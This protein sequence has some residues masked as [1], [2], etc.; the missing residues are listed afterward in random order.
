MHFVG[1]LWFLNRILK[2][3]IKFEYPSQINVTMKKFYTLLGIITIGVCAH[4]QVGI[5]TTDPKTTLDVNGAITTREISFEVVKNE[6]DINKETS[7]ADITG[8]ANATIIITTTIPET[9]GFRLIVS[10]NTTGG[11]DALFYGNVIAFQQ[12]AEFIYTGSKWKVI[13]GNRGITAD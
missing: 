3:L 12:V 13:S 1:Y 2:I 10:N 5:N 8:H 9:N 7:L 11:H 4:S 6:V